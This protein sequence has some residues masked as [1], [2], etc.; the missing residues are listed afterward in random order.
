M[1]AKLL[2]YSTVVGVYGRASSS[3]DKELSFMA[4]RGG[5][6]VQETTC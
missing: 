4:L 3:N 1:E 6:N 5:L 2:K